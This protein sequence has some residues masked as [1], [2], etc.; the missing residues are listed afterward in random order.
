M[1]LKNA[2]TLSLEPYALKTRIKIVNIFAI[3]DSINEY[4]QLQYCNNRKSPLG[5]NR[6][7]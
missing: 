4:M 6:K 2:I 3:I 1:Q 5:S 7:T